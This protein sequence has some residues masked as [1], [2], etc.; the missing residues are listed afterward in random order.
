MK[1]SPR[2]RWCGSPLIGGASMAGDLASRVPNRLAAETGVVEQR[3]LGNAKD[4]DAERSC[5]GLASDTYL[6]FSLIVTVYF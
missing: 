1:H 5:G 6:I 3:F 2:R 4:E